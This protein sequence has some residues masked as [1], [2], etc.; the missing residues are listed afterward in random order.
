[1]E[2][3]APPLISGFNHIATGTCDLDRVIAFYRDAFGATISA[4]IPSSADH[5]RMAI[6]D[7][8]GGAALNVAEVPDGSIVGDRSA[9][10]GRGPVDH[11][12]LAAASRDVLEHLQRRIV[13]AGGQVGDITLLGGTTWSLFFRDPDGMEL[14]VC[15]P[16]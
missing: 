1:M 16:K 2:R 3:S 6:I 9:I 14:E 8:G 13:D 10:G 5:P 12:G 7:M 15:A 11:F 4:E